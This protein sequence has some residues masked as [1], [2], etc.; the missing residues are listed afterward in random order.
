M[1]VQR[2]RGRRARETAD[3]MFWDALVLPALAIMLFLTVLAVGLLEK[4]GLIRICG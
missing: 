2:K 4:I 1:R 3:D